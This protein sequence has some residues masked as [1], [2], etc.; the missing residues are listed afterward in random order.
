[1]LGTDVKRHIYAHVS[2][3]WDQSVGAREC[4]Q[5]VMVPERAQIEREP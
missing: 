2:R 1:M 5:V 4:P 3:E